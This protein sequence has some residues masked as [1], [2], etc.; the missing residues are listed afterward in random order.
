MVKC[1]VVDLYALDLA[2]TSRVI[3]DQGYLIAPA[4][5]AKAGNVQ[6]YLARELGLDKSQGMASDAVINLFRPVDEVFRPETLKSFDGL[7]LT[8]DHPPKG[9]DAGNYRKVV[10]GDVQKV[11][12]GG[13]SMRGMVYV[14]DAEAVEAVKS[15]K[16]QM[17]CG[18]DF[19]ADFT[20]GTTADGVPY[21]GV[22]R[23]IVGNH[24]AIVDIARGG[25]ECRIGDQQPGAT[26][27]AITRVIDGVTLSFAD[28]T[29]A[30]FCERII[31]E[32]RK[33]VQDAQAGQRTAEGKLSTAEKA[34]ADMGEAGKKLAADHAKTVADLEAKQVKPEM[35]EALATERAGVV[36]D[37]ALL[38]KDLVVKGKT[39]P[40]I[41]HDVLTQ[42]IAKDGAPKTLALAILGGVALDKA[43]GAIVRAAFDAVVAAHGRTAPAAGGGNSSEAFGAAMGSPGTYAAGDGTS[44]GDGT[45]AR[46]AD[47][48]LEVGMVYDSNELVGL[49]ARMAAT[50]LHFQPKPPGQEQQKQ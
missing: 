29:S 25:Y 47:E 44:A 22:M 11:T 23:N 43:D 24:H 2:P 50:A 41:R 14:R 40:Q 13:D 46:A 8:L 34:L 17:S 19:E 1:S 37:S 33:S 31:A 5:L 18:Y 21:H 48:K 6:R 42:V 45:T 3:T 10:R 28:D 32:A 4:V 27:M 49:D 36:A 35:I 39:V 15:G 16:T 20:P 9:V 12:G 30:S 38:F 26:N 7:P